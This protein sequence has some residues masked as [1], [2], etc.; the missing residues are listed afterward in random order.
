MKKS[1]IS[2][3]KMPKIY[4]NKWFNYANYIQGIAQTKG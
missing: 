3:P 2:T 4:V 1:G